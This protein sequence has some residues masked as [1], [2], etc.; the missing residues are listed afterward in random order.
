MDTQNDLKY[1]V[2]FSRHPKIGATRLV[3]LFNFFHSME[4]AWRASF[5]E[6]CRAGLDE[7]IIHDFLAQK[8]T[9]N[10]DAEWEKLIKE[11]ISVLVI[12]DPKYPKLLKE[13]WNPPAILYVKGELPPDDGFNLAVVGTRKISTYGRQI[14]S[15]L[16]AELVQNGF[17]IISGLALG[18]DALAHQTTVGLGGK[19]IAVLGS[20]IDSES[21]YPVQ[22]KYL[23]GEIIKTGG[24][25]ISEYPL[26]AIAMPGNFP[27]RNR[28]VSGL[29][30]GTLVIEAAEESGALITAQCALEQN[31]EVFAV[32]GSIFNPT[33][34]GPN[35]LIKMGAKAVTS[36]NDIL[37]TLNLVK[38]ADFIQNKKIL[39][40][41]PEEEKILANLSAEPTHVDK[42]ITA[43]GLDTAKVGAIL[44]LMEMKG[45]VKNL[46]GMNYVLSK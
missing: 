25:V 17:N 40:A 22:N 32:P 2:A 9:I 11:N 21:V 34:A 42:L 3:K 12:N 39:P 5:S 4:E 20:G 14:A 7:N 46:G 16:T 24:A 8:M 35:K 44:T 15:M 6:L 41:S 26:G 19:T 31:R 1:W 13:I 23:A 38:A 30:L 29:S 27:L 43:S 36:V 28:I 45:M 37:E 33:S 18:V 10:P